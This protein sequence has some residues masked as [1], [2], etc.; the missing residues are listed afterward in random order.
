MTKLF[1]II[2]IIFFSVTPTFAL[3]I[4]EIVANP[5]GSDTGCEIIE[6]YNEE[7]K[8]YD[9]SDISLFDGG[10]LR[11]LKIGNSDTKILT[12]EFVLFLQNDFPTKNCIIPINGK[13][14]FSNFQLAN[15]KD[16]LI[17]KLKNGTELDNFKFDKDGIE[18]V[19]LEGK[20]G[21]SL[22]KI[23]NTIKESKITLGKINEIF[24]NSTSVTNNNSTTTTETTQTFTQPT[25]Y[26][27]YYFPESEKIYLNIG[28]N[29]IG[30][31]G[32]DI[33][34]EAVAVNGDKKSVN[35]NFFWSFG[36]GETAEGKNVFHNY[37][38]P[39]EYT[40]D[41]EGFAN[42]Y[43][44]NS[45]VYVKVVEPNV[46]IKLQEKN[47]LLFVEIFNL[48]K[49]EIDIGG[50]LINETALPKR[51][52][53]L[54]NKSIKIANTT[55]KLATSTSKVSLQFANKI[56]IAKDEILIKISDQKKVLEKNLSATTTQTVSVYTIEDYEKLKNTPVIVVKK[57]I[58]KNT[59]RKN[60]VNKA[61]NEQITKAENFTNE[62]FVVKNEQVSP[63]KSFLNYFGI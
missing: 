38:F 24:N 30:V 33:L 42:G 47:N 11:E 8:D 17:L 40:V 51:L 15:T 41:A 6:I 39:G 55:L 59:I 12:K 46:K 16:S 25:Y 31:V 54:P 13:Y 1:G 28:E 2:L 4:S 9:I 63:I 50:F 23:D 60:I 18:G 61:N 58:K 7:E 20:E 37:K 53:I 32:A 49:E 26:N 5:E 36:D 19:K 44:N 62:K 35:A 22:S 29:K 27:K 56:E 21:S 10:T 3:I 43:K 34:F 52:S 45:R 14:F 48:S 57:N